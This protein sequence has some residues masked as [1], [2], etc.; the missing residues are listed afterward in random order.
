MGNTTLHICRKE[1]LR[2]AVNQIKARGQSGT[3][4]LRLRLWVLRKVDLCHSLHH[5]RQELLRQELNF[6]HI[7]NRSQAPHLVTLSSQPLCKEEPRA[8]I[9][10]PPFVQLRPGKVRRFQ[11]FGGHEGIL[12]AVW[13]EDK[14]LGSVLHG[15]HTSLGWLVAS[16]LLPH[17]VDLSLGWHLGSALLT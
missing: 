9:T 2:N 6:L 1:G 17:P 4:V 7:P 16:Q 14:V 10:V 13:A 8:L 3:W 5:C 11:S 15:V 12:G